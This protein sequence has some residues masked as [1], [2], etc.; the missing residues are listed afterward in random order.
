MIYL[1]NAATTGVKPQKVIYAVNNALRQYSAN[2]GRS[3]HVLSVK[4]QEQIYYCR[5]KCAKMFGAKD[6]TAVIFTLNCTA[7]LNTVIKGCL[8]SG[9]HVVVSSLEH[10]SVMR[11]L[12]HLKK[13][14]V[15]DYDVAEVVFG[16]IQATYRAFERCIKDNTKLI[17]CTH[18][19][20]VN[21]LIM[22]IEQIGNMCKSRK[23]LFAVDA[24]QTAGV[25]NIDM[26][27][28]NID[29][30]CVAP[31][32]GLYAPMG[33]GLLIANADIEKTIIQGGTGSDSG[34]LLQLP[35][36]PEGFESGTV[37]V[38]GICGVSAGVDFVNSVTMDYIH[39]KEMKI[40]RLLYERLYSLKNVITYTP[41]PDNASS[42]PVIPFNI[43]GMPSEETAR[44]LNVKG[45]AV[46]AGLHCAPS[47]HKRLGTLDGG[48]VRVSPS[49]FNSAADADMLYK[50]L[51]SM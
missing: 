7:A 12:E 36:I 38:P 1:D 3:G 22:P 33:T 39:K 44:Y 47:A 42:V 5:K 49:F 32:K 24:A 27:A 26:Q 28:M 48:A 4:T 34:N 15:I 17:V 37:N 9:D 18:A 20:N 35:I 45:I 6:E 51:K 21:G 10:N 41:Y 8:K 29:F 13:D 11:P 23:I 30:L 43:A 40:A 50:A 25:L 46:R 19:S 2:P 14:G 16:N 31:H